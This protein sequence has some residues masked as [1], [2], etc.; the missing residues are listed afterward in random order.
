MLVGKPVWAAFCFYRNYLGTQLCLVVL[1]KYCIFRLEKPFH[2]TNH[3]EAVCSPILQ[4]NVEESAVLPPICRAPRCPQTPWVLPCILGMLNSSSTSCVLEQEQ[5]EV[6]EP[7]VSRACRRP[8]AN[9]Q[10]RSCLA[11]VFPGLTTWPFTW[12]DTSEWV[13]R[14]ILRAKRRQGLKSLE[15]RDACSSQSMPFCTLPSCL[16]DLT[17]LKVFWGLISHVRTA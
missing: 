11:G 12:R 4:I 15:R 8:R 13:K 7:R 16:Q 14:W 1:R 3:W 10:P 6:P 17:S 9:A 5:G 2:F